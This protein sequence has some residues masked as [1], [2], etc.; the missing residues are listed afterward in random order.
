M[1][2]FFMLSK[3]LPALESMFRKSS[4]LEGL[5]ASASADEPDCSMSSSCRSS[6]RGRP[7]GGWNDVTSFA[8]AAC[9]FL[10]VARPSVLGLKG[11]CARRANRRS[12]VRSA[13]AEVPS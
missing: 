4:L 1:S 6:C 3:L 13:V 11:I 9:Q 12:V 7:G 5:C 10:M 8:P 2:L